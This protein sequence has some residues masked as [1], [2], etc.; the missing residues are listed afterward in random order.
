MLFPASFINWHAPTL[1]VDDRGG[2]LLP[3][4]LDDLITNNYVRHNDPA[5]SA[6]V[7]AQLLSIDNCR[8]ASLGL[9][10]ILG[11]SPQN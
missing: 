8:A 10:Q 9:I 7:P 2:S 1:H 5:Q 6:R 4:F 3:C 11:T